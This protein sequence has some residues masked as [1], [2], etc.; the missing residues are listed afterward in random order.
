MTLTKLRELLAGDPDENLQIKDLVLKYARDPQSA[1]LF[2]HAS[3]AWNTHFFY[4]GLSPAPVKLGDLSGNLEAALTTSFG[5]IDTL[6]AAFLD[7]AAAMFAPGFVWLVWARDLPGPSISSRK[8]GWRILSTYAAGTPFP[9]AGFRQQ[10][11]DANTQSPSSYAS[12]MSSQ[13]L[14]TAGAFG[15]YSE[16]GRKASTIPPGGTSV[17]PVMCL[18]T[19]EHVWLYDFGLANKRKFLS[20]WWD[21][22]DW[23]TVDTRVPPEAKNT[24]VKFS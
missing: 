23:K 21:C 16:A 8:G 9:E 11:I 7:T 15:A 24:G 12:H 10:G 19:W 13:P 17:M 6:R 18:S 4:S 22:V 1:A 2:N 14:N 5:S 20:D 3:M